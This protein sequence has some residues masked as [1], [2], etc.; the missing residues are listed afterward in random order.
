V[1]RFPKAAAAC[2]FAIGLAIHAPALAD[3]LPSWTA[4]E[5]KTRIVDFVESV[6]NPAGTTYVPPADRVAV[7]DNDGTLW[8]EQPVYFQFLFALGNQRVGRDGVGRGTQV[9]Q[10][11]GHSQQTAQSG[12][13]PQVLVIVQRQQQKE[14]VGQPSP[15]AAKGD[16]AAGDSQGHETL[17]QDRRHLRFL[18][19]VRT[20][21]ARQAGHGRDGRLF[22]R[23]DGRVQCGRRENGGPKKPSRPS[24]NAHCSSPVGAVS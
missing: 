10:E 19:K 5:A 11:A 9:V 4:G 16:A 3:G 24:P 6:T 14:D 7:F 23:R 22:S 13:G 21:M 12:Q 20:P 2:T 17:A 15:L 18:V 1:Y 8:A